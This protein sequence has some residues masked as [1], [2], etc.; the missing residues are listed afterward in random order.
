VHLLTRIKCNERLVGA[1]YLLGK[2]YV[3]TEKS[4]NVLVYTG[5]SPYDLIH[6]IHVDGMIAVDIATSYVDVCVDILDNGNG[7]VLRIDRQHTVDT[8]IDGLESGSLLSMSVA[9]DGRL[10]IVQKR[11]RILTY[12]KGERVHRTSK[13]EGIVH[14]VEIDEKTSVVCDA[15]RTFKIA[16]DKQVDLCLFGSRYIDRS[17]N[18][19]LIMRLFS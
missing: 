11:S 17:R 5:H 14:A 6:T 7:R 19:D 1:A 2:L 10:T 13:V 4:S 8:F 3:V 9:S 12:D 16:N 15:K 18:G